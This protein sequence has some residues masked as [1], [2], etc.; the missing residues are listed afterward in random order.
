MNYTRIKR[1]QIARKQSTLLA[2]VF[3]KSGRVKLYTDDI[4]L[5]RAN[6][7]YKMIPKTVLD[8]TRDYPNNVELVP[9]KHYIYEEIEH[10]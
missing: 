2:T 6:K 4:T 8:F 1:V 3:Y 10:D 9:E 5:V 7:C